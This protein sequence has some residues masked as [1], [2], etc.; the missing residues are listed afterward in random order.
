MVESVVLDSTDTEDYDRPLDPPAEGQSVSLSRLL[1][2]TDW[3]LSWWQ[4]A[5]YEASENVW[6]L[7][8]RFWALSRTRD[9]RL[10]LNCES[11]P[12]VDRPSRN[13]MGPSFG[14]VVTSSVSI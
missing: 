7:L 13:D 2:G 11:N 1:H 4:V 10:N 14:A 6:G 8:N 5:S 12:R 3:T 9:G